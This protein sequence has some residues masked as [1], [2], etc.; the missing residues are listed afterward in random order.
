MP[1][2]VNT[3]SGNQVQPWNAHNK[4]G[5]VAAL[6]IPEVGRQ[7]YVELKWRVPDKSERPYLKK[8][9]R[10]WRVTEEATCG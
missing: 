8:Q 5:V 1:G 6:V 4:P 10:G 2:S 3:S 9:G 7:S